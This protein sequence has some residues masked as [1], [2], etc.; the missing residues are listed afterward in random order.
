MNLIEDGVHGV[1]DHLLIKLRAIQRPL[2]MWV[3]P[4][5]DVAIWPHDKSWRRSPP[6]PDATLVGTYTPRITC[7]AVRDDLGARLAEIRP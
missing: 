1:A 7:K 3:S 4:A 2:T 6:P 5:G